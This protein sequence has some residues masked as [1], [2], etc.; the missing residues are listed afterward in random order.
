[1]SPKYLSQYLIIKFLIPSAKINIYI[2]LFNEVVE[3]D[4][5]QKSKEIETEHIR[6]REYVQYIL[7]LFP[8]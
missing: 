4:I 8:S 3:N 7:T 6:K 1:M 5:Y 2:S